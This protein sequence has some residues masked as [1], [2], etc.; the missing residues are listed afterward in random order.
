MAADTNMRAKSC[1]NRREASCPQLVRIC[2]CDYLDDRATRSDYGYALALQFVAFVIYGCVEQA[3]L[4]V[5]QTVRLGP[6]PITDLLAKSRERGM[7]GRWLNSLHEA[8]AIA[9][10]IAFFFPFLGSNG[11]AE[12]KPPFPLIYPKSPQ[13]PCTISFFL[14]LSLAP[15]RLFVQG[16]RA[17]CIPCVPCS[18]LRS[19]VGVAYTT[20][21]ILWGIAC[22]LP[23]HYD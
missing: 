15:D 2:R 6:F 23:S 12:S 8:S 7:N 17:E 14:I 20:G 11:M 19:R 9:G 4:E 13:Q 21:D 22:P 10:D 3:A 16:F 1:S 5:V 18:G